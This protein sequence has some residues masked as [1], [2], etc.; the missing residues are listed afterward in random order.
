MLNTELFKHLPMDIIINHIMPYTY[1]PQYKLLL[2][3]IRSFTKDFQFVKDVYYTEYN[4]EIL[5]YD[6]ITFCNNNM[7]PVYGIDMKYEY[8]LKRNYL[9]NLK[10]HR[11]LVEYIF[12]NVHVNLIFKTENKIKFLWGI[13]TPPERMRFIYKYIMEFIAE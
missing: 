5:I 9:L 12:T 2:F 4:S 13:M 10:C 6:L 3:D 7:A 11:E 8:V 1:K